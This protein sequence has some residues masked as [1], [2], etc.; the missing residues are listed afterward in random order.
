MTSCARPPCAARRRRR[1]PLGAALAPVTRSR[2]DGGRRDRGR[3]R[4]RGVGRDP[5]SADCR[6]SGDHRR[7]CC[8]PACSSPTAR[9]R[10]AESRFAVSPDG[11]RLVILAA[12]G[13]G[14]PR[15]WI[16]SLASQGFQPLPDTERLYPFWSADSEF[17]GF[18]AGDQIKKSA[19]PAARRSRW[20]RED[21]AARGTAAVPSCS[22]Q[23][24]VAALSRGGLRWRTNPG[25]PAQRRRRRGSAR[26]SGVPA[27]RTNF[28]TSG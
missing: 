9:R 20:R 12:E 10:N 4:P 11:R 17:V 24:L 22:R 3:R 19:W 23:G 5:G 21:E 15:L 16:R 2:G 1:S 14:A 13:S 27:G 6:G 18:I 26:L 8:P 25:D 28:S 7:W